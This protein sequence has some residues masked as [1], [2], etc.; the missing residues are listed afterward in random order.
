MGRGIM[1]AAKK[2]ENKQK[3][4]INVTL[5]RFGILTTTMVAIIVI[6]VLLVGIVLSLTPEYRG[7]FWE[8]RSEFVLNIGGGIFVLLICR[9]IYVVTSWW[10]RSVTN[11]MCDWDSYRVYLERTLKMKRNKNSV[12]LHLNL[13]AAEVVLGRYDECRAEL[14][15]INRLEDRL[16]EREKFI[17]MQYYISYLYWTKDWDSLREKSKEISEMLQSAENIQGNEKEVLEEKILLYGYLMED[18]W[19][20]AVSLLEKR[21]GVSV[22]G[23]VDRAY[24]LGKAYY[25]M[26]DYEAAF[27]NLTFVAAWGGNTKYVSLAKEMLSDMPEKEKNEGT[28]VRKPLNQRVVIHKRIR[29]SLVWVAVLAGVCVL[30]LSISNIS[31]NSVEEVYCKE[32]WIGQKDQ[33]AVLYREEF[34]D[35]EMAVLCDGDKIGYCLCEKTGKESGET[36]KIIDSLRTDQH[37]ETAQMEKALL[38]IQQDESEREAYQKSVLDSFL[39]MQMWTVLSSFYRENSSFY[40]DGFS[41]TGVSCYPD[42]EEY[43]IGGQQVEVEPVITIDETQFYIWHIEGADLDSMDFLTFVNRY[44]EGNL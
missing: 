3:Q 31:G 19:E 44:Y 40:P 35:Y 9:I 1:K 43:V 37:M 34:D 29:F 24:Y 25:R 22:Y 21:E 7:T 26:G 13:F 5:V 30:T 14:E 20:E 17:F 4:Y 33:A 16:P 12:K 15:E 32:Y 23:Q 28:S 10:F 18:N 39:T 36:Y 2:S 6:T 42:V 27:S 11:Q 41:Y 38:Y 8:K